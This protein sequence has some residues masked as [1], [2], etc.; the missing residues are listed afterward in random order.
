MAALNKGTAYVFGTGTVTS[1]QVQSSSLTD[2]FGIRVEVKDSDGNIVGEGLGAPQRTG[3]ITLLISNV[4][5]IPEPGDSL[6]YDG[7]PFWITGVEESM[8]NDNYKEVT[9]KVEY[10]ASIA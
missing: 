7:S 10:I 5:A 8:S 1:A 9:L 4:Y 6:T 2:D 3:D